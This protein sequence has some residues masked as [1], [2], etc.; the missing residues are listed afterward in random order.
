MIPLGCYENNVYLVYS[1]LIMLMVN[2]VI[3]TFA[4]CINFALSFS[5]VASV[6]NCCS[7]SGVGGVVTSINLDRMVFKEAAGNLESGLQDFG[8][9]SN[10]IANI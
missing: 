4:R 5:L 7:N 10:R 1:T 8:G 9:P 2:S 3:H 6:A